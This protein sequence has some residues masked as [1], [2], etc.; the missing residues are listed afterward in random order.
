MKYNINN[1]GSI[2]GGN[3]KKTSFAILLIVFTA[4]VLAGCG[5][6]NDTTDPLSGYNVDVNLPFATAQPGDGASSLSTP[7]PTV[8]TGWNGERV[9]L[10]S[11]E[12]TELEQGSIGT[13]VKNLQ[14]RLIELGYMNGTASGTFDNATTLA[15]K[16]FEAAYG[17]QQTGI[18]TQLMQ[19]YLYSTTAKVYQGDASATADT[20]TATVYRTLQRGDSG[21]DV[22]RLKQRLVE[23]GYMTSSSGSYFD[24]DTENGV[25]A[26]ESAYNRTM[27]GVATVEL[28]NYLY[29]AQAKSAWQVAAEATPVPTPTPTPAPWSIYR[30]LSK[31]DSGSEVTRL[32]N[33]LRELGYMTSKADGKYGDKTVEAVKAFE[34]KYGKAQTG[35]ATAILQYYLFDDTALP[36]SVATATPTAQVVTTTY[37]MLSYGDYGDAVV[38]LQERL[39]EL[40]YLNDKA[41]GYYGKNTQ[42]A[43]SAFEV[44]NG[45]TATGVATAAMQSYLYSDSAVGQQTTTIDEVTT[46]YSELKLGSYGNDVSILQQRLAELGYYSGTISGYF[47]AATDAAVRGF[48][49]AYGRNETGVA[50]EL[51]QTY[52]YSENAKR[53]PAQSSTVTYTTLK[54]GDKGDN[55]AQLQRRLIELGYLGG[56][57]DGI[58]GDGTADAIKSFEAA[59]GMTQTGTATSSLQAEIYSSSARRNTGSAAGYSYVT[60]SKGD[61]GSEVTNLQNRLIALGY[62]S[63]KASGTYD[64]ATVNAVKAF[65]KAMGLT[66]TGTATS[67]LQRELFSAGAATSTTEETVVNVN[68]KAYVS[69][70]ETYVYSSLSA[71]SA[72]SVISIGTEVTIV[73]TKGKWAEIKNSRGYVG[74]ALLENF[75][76]TQPSSASTSTQVVTVNK[77]AVVNT[78]KLVV[79]ASPSDDARQLGT[80]KQDTYVTW[81]RTRGEWA[82]IQNSKGEVG[83]VHTNQIIVVSDADTGTSIDTDYSVTSYI[84]LKYKSK[85]D[86]VKRLQSRLKELGYYSGD[87]GG[88]YLEKTKAAVESFEKAIGLSSTGVATA[89]LQDILY[90]SAAPKSGKYKASNL[91]TF[92][93]LSYGQKSEAVGNMQEKLVELGYLNAGKYTFATYDEATAIAVMDVQLAMGLSG[94]D[95][96]A[97]RE[98]QAFL[99]SNASKAIKK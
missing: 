44:A 13:K 99:L 74:Y 9:T 60:L 46:V 90:S 43:V 27:T 7:E 88:N 81:L 12:Y 18:A 94:V 85:G 29:S 50:T 4:F 67:A 51:L 11:G 53:N 77:P 19:Y 71:D 66:Q 57:V 31:G 1:Y 8:V 78:E 10:N 73:R 21:A 89:G 35:I 14:K 86:A 82:E 55:V 36:A 63:G 61:T 26:F 96:I 76:Y 37:Y 30:D 28:Q 41:D 75:T 16:R 69:V 68:K 79:F 80:L 95:G 62:M 22:Q 20:S 17:R 49:A 32:Q 48:E 70:A 92:S 25:K 15:V 6:K 87:I 98:L 42:A 83:Y 40:G 64:N 34:A 91:Y 52:L 58:Y 97:S 84:E 54:K 56:T 93:S 45:R 23:L 2:Y 3:M 65:Q 5:P 59:Y 33:R 39:I 24:L 47:D 38:M 72:Y